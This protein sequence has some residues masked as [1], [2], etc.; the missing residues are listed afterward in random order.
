MGKVSLFHALKAGSG[1]LK[2]YMDPEPFSLAG[3]DSLSDAMS[4]VANFVGESIPIVE[5]ET[6]VLLGTVTEGDLFNAVIEVQG[7]IVKQE[8]G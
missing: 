4:K 5:M 3:T 6:G 1:P 7:E 2:D 8:R